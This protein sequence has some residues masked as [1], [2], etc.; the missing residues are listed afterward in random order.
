MTSSINEKT[1]VSLPIGI[2]WSVVVSSVA[3]TVWITTIILG[4]QYKI[5]S[6]YQT[7]QLEHREMMKHI[8]SME[9]ASKA[10]VSKKKFE[11]AVVEAYHYAHSTT[12][13][14]HLSSDDYILRERLRRA[15]L[16]DNQ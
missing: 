12:N 11:D 14:T 15:M 6:L 8:T 3:A 13:H 7:N 2:A 1:K 10:Y 5:E 4:L 9:D 16:D